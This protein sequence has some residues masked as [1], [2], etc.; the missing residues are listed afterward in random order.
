VL[1]GAPIVVF[2]ERGEPCTFDLGALGYAS[3]ADTPLSEVAV[4]ATGGPR[5]GTLDGVADNLTYTPNPEHTGE[6]P[7]ELRLSDGNATSARRDIV[8][9]TRDRRTCLTL[10]ESTGERTPS[11]VYDLNP[12]GEGLRPTYCDMTENGG[13]WALVLKTASDTGNYGYTDPHWEDA[14]VDAVAPDVS[15]SEAK[16]DAFVSHP[17]EEV[18]VVFSPL[19]ATGD[20]F[21]QHTSVVLDVEAASMREL[22]NRGYT[23]A[24]GANTNDFLALQ[25]DSNIQQHCDMLGFNVDAEGPTAVASHR[26]T[27][28]GVIGNN[29]ESCVTTDSS[30][31]VGGAGGVCS[32]GA[33]APL[34]HG[35][36]HSCGDGDDISAGTFVSVWVRAAD[37]VEVRSSC[38]AH[39]NALRRNNGF[40]YVDADGALGPFPPQKVVCLN[41][42]DGGGWMVVARSASTVLYPDFGWK[43]RVGTVDNTDL[44][45]S[46]DLSRMGV[47]FSE[48]ATARRNGGWIPRDNAYAWPA[49]GL[50]PSTWL[51]TAT[52]DD[53]RTARVVLGDCQPST[54]SRLGAIGWVNSSIVY[55]FG[56][57]GSWSGLYPE[58]FRIYDGWDG[59]SVTGEGDGDAHSDGVFADD[60][61]NDHGQLLNRHGI[62][63]AR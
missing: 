50:L 30:I 7:F 22:M 54:P 43:H 60:S 25:S 6:D 23:P 40:F 52:V 21:D 24:G 48:V 31:G 35:T 18:R 44:P 45:F 39:W 20:V 9:Y 17:I 42:Y 51:N 63:M 32:G 55:Y 2:C 14:H 27:R 61:C 8:I 59:F 34:T 1:T 29:E 37:T 26:R 62:M 33:P 57:N 12:D 3:D 58:G 11:G 38:T 41:D 56:Y 13:G 10:H 53:E 46:L 5:G 4:E 36:Y 15:R 19:T 28:I 47:P 16:L 49:A